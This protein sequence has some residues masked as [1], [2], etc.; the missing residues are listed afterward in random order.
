MRP[1]ERP[2][3]RDVRVVAA[4]VG[5]AD[6]I[7]RFISKDLD[8]AFVL[9]AL[10]ESEETSHAAWGAGDGEAGA[11]GAVEDICRDGFEAGGMLFPAHVPGLE[12]EV[13]FCEVDV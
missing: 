10:L 4:V 3:V 12:F 6:G 1:V 2:I 13:V 5:V 11:E 8:I 9:A 7:V